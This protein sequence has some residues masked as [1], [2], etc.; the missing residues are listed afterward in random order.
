MLDFKQPPALLIQYG[1]DLAI[2]RRLDRSLRDRMR[3]W[4]D[5]GPARKHAGPGVMGVGDRGA[6]DFWLLD[7][8]GLV[9]VR[10][11]GLALDFDKDALVDKAVSDG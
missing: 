9:L 8:D 5:S 10:P 11:L 3:G 4:I 1:D 6:R 2:V 7:L